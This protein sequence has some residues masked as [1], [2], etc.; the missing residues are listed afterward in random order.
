M[1]ILVDLLMVPIRVA[2]WLFVIV[3]KVISK[4]E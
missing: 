4:L 1:G 2:F 3:L